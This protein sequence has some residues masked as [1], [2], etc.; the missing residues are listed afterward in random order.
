MIRTQKRPL[1]RREG[2]ISLNSAYIIGSGF[3]GLGFY[4]LFVG[5]HPLAALLALLSFIYYVFIYTLLLK[6]RTHWNTVLGGVCGSLGPL[7]GELAVNNTVS[8]Y[9]L[10]MFLFLFLWQPPHFW[11]LAIHYKEDYRRARIPVL[12]ISKGIRASLEQ[13]LL[14]QFLL[15]FL[16]LITSLP[17]LALFGPVFLWPSLLT[18]LAVLYAMWSLRKNYLKAKTKKVSFKPLRVFALS[19]AHMLLWHLALG[20]DLYLRFWSA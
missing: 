19:I 13:I 15:C 12:P 6:P 10:A 9:S 20:L 1:V 16:I 11:C 3:L 4:I 14:Y 8:E 5:S 2:K 18:G 7:I 17:P